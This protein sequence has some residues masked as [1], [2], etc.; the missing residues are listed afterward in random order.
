MN[1]SIIRGRR[2]TV[3]LASVLDYIKQ[4]I[5]KE[6]PS[7]KIIP[8]HFLLSV[9]DNEQCAAYKTINKIMFNE[10]IEMLKSWYRQYLSDKCIDNFTGMNEPRYDNT[11]ID[12]IKPLNGS[13]KDDSVSSVDVLCNIIET[14]D[15]VRKSFR[16]LGVTEE[17]IK[18][19]LVLSKDSRNDDTQMSDKKTVDDKPSRTIAVKNKPKQVSNE[20]ERNLVN[21]NNLAAE[22]KIDEVYENDDIILEIFTNL[23]KRY[24]NNVILVGESGCGKTATIKHI[25]N[26]LINNAV[27]KPF[28]KKKLVMLDFMSLVSGTSY[29]G[30]FEIKFNAIINDARKDGNYI[31]FIDDIQ[32]ILGDKSKFGEIDVESILDSILADKNIQFICTTNQKAYKKYIENS[33]SLKRRLQ[34]IEM[35]TPS[36]DKSIRILERAKVRLESYHD[37]YCDGSIIEICVK[38]CK[39][40]INDSVLPDSAI[41]VIDKI[42]AKVSIT[43]KDSDAIRVI[44]EQL[45]ENTIEKE[46]IN[47]LPYKDYDKIDELTRCEIRLKSHLSIIEKEEKLHKKAYCVTEDDIK[48]VISEMAN[49]PL[50]NLSSDKNEFE[51]LRKIN[52]TIKLSV[53]G[54]DDAVDSVCNAIKKHK[55]GISN[56]DKPSVFL[57]VGSTGTGKTLLAKKIAKEVYGDEKYLVRLDMSEYA[58]KT[59]VTKLYGASSGY[60]GYDNG[61]ILTEAVKKNK[62]CVLLL[63]EIEKA[64]DEVHNAFL[65]L[66]DEGRM[67]DNTGCMVDFKNTTII[68]TSN[69]GARELDEKGNGIGFN[70]DSLSD[71]KDIIDKSI[72]KKFKPEFINRINK[73]IYF[74]KLNE[75]N[76]KSII[77]IELKEL[78]KRLNNADYYLEENFIDSTL[79]DYIYSRIDS[80]RYGARTIIRQIENDIEDKIMDYI[81]TNNI[82][83]KHIF[84]RIE[85]SL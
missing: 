57:F 29:R 40:Y 1:D 49:M 4:N 2:M 62:Y 20:V 46:R 27:P 37:I 71:G 17:Q 9:L 32:S 59:S 8:E 7:D 14:D 58:D 45:K 16:L 84:N 31:F 55:L 81:L 60:V 3:E 23:Q 76:I 78:E 41:N 15:A 33:T 19:N 75:K 38:L 18:E 47:S 36:V 61:G 21:L 52:E 82:D 64:N 10:T 72:K 24:Q 79:V 6:Y 30:S 28:Q 73:I 70:K 13:S 50:K 5:I 68:M 54:Q 67:T 44:K 80:N 56:A 42:G 48:N 11:L 65:Q 51:R 85:L 22:G 74:N 63:D 35:E 83:K 39:R 53:I 43:E 26:M 66:F 69:V 12:A 34:K 25:A 77:H